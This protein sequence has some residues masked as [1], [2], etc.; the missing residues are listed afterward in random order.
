M[1]SKTASSAKTA[2]ELPEEFSAP[3]LNDLF[4]K[5]RQ[6]GHLSLSEVREALEST[7]LSKKRQTKV[8]RTL[9]D[10]AIEVREDET[11]EMPTKPAA[12]KST[13][14]TAAAS[15]AAPAKPATA[16]VA[17]K[18]TPAK[19]TVGKKATPAKAAV[20]K[21]AVTKAAVTEAAVT[22]AAVTEAAAAKA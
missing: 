20:T 7:E 3:G 8:L 9:S 10:N 21:T 6:R 14:K 11:S 17:E 13:T 5:G 2:I 18:A 4:K 22:E 19:A 16:T 15:K 1:T 12:R